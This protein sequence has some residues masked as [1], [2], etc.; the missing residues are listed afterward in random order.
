ML[1]LNIQVL[2]RL[3]PLLELSRTLLLT[4]AGAIAEEVTA[5]EGFKIVATMNP[6]GDYGK[7]E[8]R[9]FSSFCYYQFLICLSRCQ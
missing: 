1:N 5:T 6:G 8:V 2:E 9:F 3:N 4:D 7:K